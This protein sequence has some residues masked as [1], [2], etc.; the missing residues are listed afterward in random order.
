MPVGGSP[1]AYHPSNV[2]A[3]NRSRYVNQMSA[4]GETDG[5]APIPTPRTAT[6]GSMRSGGWCSQPSERGARDA[7]R[8]QPPELVEDAGGWILLRPL[9]R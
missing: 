6:A 4:H 7:L 1:E 3:S 9:C 2:P 5:L 8:Q